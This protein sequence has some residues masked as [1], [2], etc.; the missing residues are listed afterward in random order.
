MSDPTAD[1]L[2]RRIDRLESRFGSMESKLD[3]VI[4]L[5]SEKHGANAERLA[6][7]ESRM[8]P[9]PGACVA[10][11]EAL[12]DSANR[13]SSLERNMAELRGIGIGIKSVWLLLGAGMVAA[14]T[15]LLNH[16]GLSFR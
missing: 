6:S 13:I 4:T 3:T 9:R 14:A 2:S 16:F 8:C 7:V 1:E 11:A 15:W 5:L 10:L 12:G